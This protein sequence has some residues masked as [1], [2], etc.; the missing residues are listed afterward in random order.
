MFVAVDSC[1]MIDWSSYRKNEILLKIFKRIF[2]STEILN[3]IKSKK[4]LDMVVD[5]I[6]NDQIVLIELSRDDPEITKIISEVNKI[7]NFP[8]IDTPEA[9]ALLL[10]KRGKIDNVLSENKATIA[11]V[12]LEDFRNIKVWTAIEVIQEAIVQ[13]ILPATNAQDIEKYYQEYSLDTGHEFRKDKLDK[14]IK[15]LEKLF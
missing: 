7:D 5:W 12:E 3:E 14:I 1:F 11:A 6:G 10:A 2:M 13:G 8:T 15:T 4:A 9:T